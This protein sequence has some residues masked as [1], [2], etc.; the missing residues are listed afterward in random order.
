MEHQLELRDLRYILAVAET[1][2]FGR[3]ASKLGIAQPNLSQQIKKIEKSLGYALFERTTRGVTL[4]RVGAF[5]AKRAELLQANLQ[6]A[7]QVAQRIGRG[8][9]GSLT[10]GFSGSVM[11]SRTPRVIERYRRA[12]P[13]VVLQLR[14]LYADEQAALL[15][16][17]TLDISIIRDGRPCQGLEMTPLLVEPFVAVLPEHHSL[18]QRRSFLLA[19][20][21]AERFVLFSPKIANLAYQRTIDVCEANGFRP[22]IVQE[23]P[24]W[25]TVITLVA[26][27]MGVSLAPAC[28]AQLN[29]PGV[30]FRPIRSKGRTSIDLWTKIASNNPAVKALLSIAKQEF[31]A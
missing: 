9:E 21:R 28:T 20:L 19:M 17:G 7:I 11:Y 18:A 5:F 15:L 29:I 8:E 12:Y 14:E 23:A 26:A 13:K 3:A 24:Q 25:V 22:D 31:D 16:D 30:V 6:D 10:V 2:H 27:G 1:L 4:T